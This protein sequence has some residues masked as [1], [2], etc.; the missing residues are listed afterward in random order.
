VYWDWTRTRIKHVLSRINLVQQKSTECDQY[1][2]FKPINVCITHSLTQSRIYLSSAAGVPNSGVDSRRLEHLTF[3]LKE[4]LL[5]GSMST[6][7]YDLRSAFMHSDQVFLGRPRLPRHGNLILVTLLIHAVEK[8]VP[9]LPVQH[10]VVPWCSWC[11]D[12]NA[13]ISVIRIDSCIL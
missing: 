2:I 1:K 10:L 8:L 12:A 11:A 7:L 13:T 3:D 6:R 9:K 4:T 5:S